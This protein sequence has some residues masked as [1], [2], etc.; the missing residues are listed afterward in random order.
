VAHLAEVD[1]RRLH[2]LRGRSL[3]EYCQ[4]C[5]GFSESEAWYRICAARM[6]R[7]FP[8]VFALLETR[9]IHLTAVALIAKYLT[10]ENH[11]ELLAEV[12]GKTKRQI[13]ELLVRRF[14]KADV[15]SQLRVIP[16]GAV[17]AGPTA[18]LEPLREETY[19]LRLNVSS[20]LAA[21][22]ELARDLMSH[23]NPSGDLAVVVE[24]AL[25]VLIE[26]LRARRFGQTKRL[27]PSSEVAG[28]RAA[29]PRQVAAQATT[30]EGQG[31]TPAEA[32]RRTTRPV[33]AAERM[34]TSVAERQ[35]TPSAWVGAEPRKRA[36]ISHGV[37][38]QV[39]Q[40][41]GDC[42]TYVGRDGNRC[43]A[44]AFLEFHHE[45]AWARGGADSAE[46]LRVL[47]RAHNRLLAEQELGTEAVQRAIQRRGGSR[48]S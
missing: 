30:G 25:D 33:N 48:S 34:T 40:R 29:A 20:Q 16:A 41:D 43:S 19:C 42:C 36:H 7:K 5:L 9:E 24:R 8:L 13:L 4:V 3:F 12:R 6:G 15:T 10:E 45:E 39:A 37:R 2:L 18:T 22:L 28:P 21:K 32:D 26:K 23:A 17:A 47:C 35:L 11:R 46:N 38:R 27:R 1:A 44:R 14:P 31:M